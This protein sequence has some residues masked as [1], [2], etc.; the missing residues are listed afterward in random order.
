[1][2]MRSQMTPAGALRC[3]IAATLMA[4]V[5]PRIEAQSSSHASPGESNVDERTR[6]ELFAARDKVWRAY[7]AN[8]TATLGWM[9]PEHMVAI[10]WGPGPWSDRNEVL[11]GSRAFAAGGGKLL[12]LEFPR[13]EIQLFGDV[14]LVYSFFTVETQQGERRQAV[15]GRA[16]EVFVRRGGRWINPAWHLDSTGH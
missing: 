14:A 13:S 7:F 2:M 8:D 16:T 5:S 6:A 12:R 9:I 1:M 15:N 11:A 4:L 10:G 3:A